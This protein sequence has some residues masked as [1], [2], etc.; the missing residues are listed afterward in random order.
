M[1]DVGFSWLLFRVPFRKPRAAVS[2]VLVQVLYVSLADL[3]WGGP[4]VGVV[5][6]AQVLFASLLRFVCGGLD[7]ARF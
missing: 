3:V 7:L 4:V 6:L 5:V 1:V 2:V